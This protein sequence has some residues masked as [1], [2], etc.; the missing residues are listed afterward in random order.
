LPHAFD[1]IGMLRQ[2]PYGIASGHG[3]ETNAIKGMTHFIGFAPFI[4]L[5]GLGFLLR[6]Q[7][8]RGVAGIGLGGP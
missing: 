5:S 7:L 2:T 1:G 3:D 4:M 6:F 8:D